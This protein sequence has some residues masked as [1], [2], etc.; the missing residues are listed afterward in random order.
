MTYCNRSFISLNFCEFVKLLTVT[1]E[2]KEGDT[3]GVCIFSSAGNLA[4]TDFSF[5][6]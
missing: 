5:S 6:M 4:A 2:V 1:D 3:A